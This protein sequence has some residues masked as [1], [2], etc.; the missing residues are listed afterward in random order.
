MYLPIRLLKDSSVSWKCG[1]LGVSC[2]EYP[3]AHLCV[4]MFHPV[5][6]WKSQSQMC[7]YK[8]KACQRGQAGNLG[9]WD[10][11][12]DLGE[13]SE[14]DWAPN[15]LILWAPGLTPFDWLKEPDFMWNLQTSGPLNIHNLLKLW[16]GQTI[17]IY[18]WPYQ[19]S[20]NLSK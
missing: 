19:P 1:Q 3:S 10:M 16:S 15:Y 13:Q 14:G 18:C 6:Y 2:R 11:P 20:L 7:S 5:F 17:Y 12:P 8:A 9:E 4:D